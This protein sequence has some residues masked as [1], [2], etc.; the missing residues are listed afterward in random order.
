MAPFCYEELDEAR[1]R[2]E[3]QLSQ[4]LVDRKR[5]LYEFR[6][7]RTSSSALQAHRIWA[8]QLYAAI[9]IYAHAA[10]IAV[11]ARVLELPREIRD[12]IY[13]HLWVG[14]GH[15]DF[16]RHL[17]YWWELFDQPWII[18]GIDP[19]WNT[20]V[21]DLKPPH[22]IDQAFVGPN[23]A[24]EVLVQLQDAI[25]KDLRPCDGNPISEFSLIDA[26][27]EEFVRKDTFGVGLTMEELVRN[28]DLR[29]NFQCDVLY[30]D[31][32]ER[33]GEVEPNAD[34]TQETRSC[35]PARQKHLADLEDGVKALLTIPYS[36]RITIHDGEKKRLSSRP[37]I[38]T[39]VI[40]QENAIDLEISLVPILRLVA[41]A[42]KG[43]SKTGFTVR[44]LYHSDEVGLKVL[45]SED[46]WTWSDKD[47]EDNLKEKNTC[48][49]DVEEWDR[50]IQPVV[51][52]HIRR[53]LFSVEADET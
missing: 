3:Q 51:W 37:R 41:S 18:Q 34:E 46:T 47:W 49:V 40:R 16:Q 14:D 5:E 44:I 9:L 21:T 31:E 11:V 20:Y 48:K 10:N 29:I 43:L 19:P 26:S 32:I 22:F 38:I 27:M 23:F 24:K 7:Q 39:L 13:M 8:S 42:H 33:D 6:W 50:E 1:K 12:T 36:D 17:L 28:L 52:A 15:Q 25:G 30:G 4:V 2:A 45:F 53:I 35:E